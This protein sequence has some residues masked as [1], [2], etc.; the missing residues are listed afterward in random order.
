M[1]ISMLKFSDRFENSSNEYFRVNKFVV[2]FDLLELMIELDALILLVHYPQLFLVLAIKDSVDALHLSTTNQL[3][4]VSSFLHPVPF[5]CLAL[6]RSRFGVPDIS[7]I[8]PLML[9]LS[10]QFLE[11]KNVGLGEPDVHAALLAIVVLEK[12]DRGKH[13]SQLIVVKFFTKSKS[14]SFL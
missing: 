10:I 13:L 6:V 9:L 4:L 8:P 2:S 7:G 11:G 5:H 12:N 14:S 3:E 1:N